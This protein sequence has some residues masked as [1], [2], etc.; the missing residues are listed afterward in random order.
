MGVAFLGKDVGVDADR[1]LATAAAPPT[2]KPQLLSDDLFLPTFVDRLC[3]ADSNPAKL[4]FN[5][6]F[7]LRTLMATPLTIE[8]IAFRQAILSELSGNETIR[9]SFLEL[10]RQ[11]FTLL[12]YFRST[13][14]GRHDE[15]LFRLD[16]FAQ[17][18]QSIDL[19]AESFGASKSGLKRLHEVASN[20]QR[21]PEYQTIADLLQY[22]NNQGSATVQLRVGADGRIRDL[23]VLRTREN[24]ANRFYRSPVQRFASKLRLWLLGYGFSEREI[25]N[26]LIHA[27][28][29]ELEPAILPLVHLLGQCQFYLASLAFKSLAEARSLEV[30]LPDFE[31]D[32]PFVM[33]S[34][35]NPLLLEGG[36]M[37]VPT[38]LSFN[39][40]RPLVIVTGPNSGGKTKLLQAIGLA[41]LFG[42]SGWFMP[43]SASNLQIV[44]GMFVSTLDEQ[45]SSEEEGRFGREL[46]RIRSIFENLPAGSMI[47]ID[48]LCSGT[49]PSEGSEI[50]T[51]VFALFRRHGSSAIV[52]THFLDFVRHFADEAT[53]PGLEFL[54]VQLDDN[55]RSTFTFE[56]GVATSSLAAATAQRLGVTFDQLAKLIDTQNKS[57][58]SR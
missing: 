46:I 57:A 41:Q 31:E 18:K 1:A 24:R 3:S 29:L 40:G 13:S 49:N 32:C 15:A 26:R 50:L 21:S 58:A 17:V 51:M 39:T 2:W 48:E 4:P 14:S 9:A 43:A 27:I 8:E 47:L 20:V 42:Q 23:E 55:Q 36:P 30:C 11:L 44:H 19:M 53:L 25:I 52:S 54:R 35:F 28:Y 37:P 56:P 45:T 10:H 5:R 34:L 22:E 6:E 12:S 16:V 7:L 33:E 38:S